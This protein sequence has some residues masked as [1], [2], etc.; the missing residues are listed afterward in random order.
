MRTGLVEKFTGGMVGS[1]LGD[2]IGELAFHYQDRKRLLDR[3]HH[4]DT[5]EY[6]DD[7]AMA[8]GLAESLC[9]KKGI[10]R[11]HLGGTF[12]HNY[13]REPW[14]GYAAGP[15]AIFAMVRDHGMDY[16]DA[17]KTLFGGE[18]S[19]GNGAAM[20]ITPLGLFF[21]QLG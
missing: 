10:D 12:H 21:H 5:L 8:V 9:E 3:L 19:L 1:A 20:R 7:T 15:P 11:Q 17:A 13:L 16:A 18:G 14:R 2:A 6:T 4:L